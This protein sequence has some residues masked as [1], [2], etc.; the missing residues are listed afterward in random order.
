LSENKHLPVCFD[1]HGTANLMPPLFGKDTHIH[2]TDF[3]L[4]ICRETKTVYA[5]PGL[6][7]N[8]SPDSAFQ[9]L[10]YSGC[11]VAFKM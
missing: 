8:A 6:K 1:E 3:S 5:G 11:D 7:L 2:P 10:S 9:L 4:T